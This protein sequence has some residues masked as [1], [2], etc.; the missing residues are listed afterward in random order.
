MSEQQLIEEESFHTHSGEED[1]ILQECSSAASLSLEAE[2]LQTENALVATSSQEF[3]S[4]IK[5]IITTWALNEVRVPKSSISSLL[6]GLHTI[7]NEL[8]KSFKTLL[9]RPK[10]IYKSMLAGKYVYFPNWLSALTNA[11][12]YFYGHLRD[13]EFFLLVNVDGLPLFG[14]SPDY[15]LYPI[16]VSLYRCKMRPICV[17]IYCTEKSSNREMPPAD[18]LLQDFLLDVYQLRSVGISCN[19]VNF[20]L[21]NNGIYVCDAPARSSLKQIKS[22]SGYSCCERCV[23]TGEY[24]LASKH[25]CFVKTN[26]QPRSDQSFLMQTDA[27]HHKGRSVLAEFGV[28]MVDGFPLDYMHLCCLGVMKRLLSRWKGVP[29]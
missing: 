27:S 21:G 4:G 1:E 23:I 18:V 3:L 29:R 24:D 11:L 15:K 16:L 26:C 9:L 20:R 8:P 25:E 17:D 7:H 6:K 2:H 28:S 10:L 19:N 13:V 12:V 14:H 22:H 5:Q